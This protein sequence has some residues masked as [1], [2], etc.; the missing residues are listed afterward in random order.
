MYQHPDSDP[1]LQPGE[2][3]ISHVGTAPGRPCHGGPG[4]PAHGLA[5]VLRGASGWTPCGGRRK[6]GT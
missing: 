3:G 4:E 1:G 5:S 2:R 6:P